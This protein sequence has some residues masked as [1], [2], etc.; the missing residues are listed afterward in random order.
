LATRGFQCRTQLAAPSCGSCDGDALTVLFHGPGP[1]RKWVKT[2]SGGYW[3]DEALA[4][5]HAVLTA[6]RTRAQT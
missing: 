6:S 3:V 4:S 5:G 2:P 1:G